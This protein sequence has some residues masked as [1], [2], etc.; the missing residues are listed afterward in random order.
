MNFSLSELLAYQKR[1]PH[2]WRCFVRDLLHI[3]R[4]KIN[5]KSIVVITTESEGLG[6]YLW[7]RNYYKVIKKHFEDKNGCTIILLGMANWKEFVET[8]DL[9]EYL[10]IFRPFESCDSHKFIERLFFYLFTADLYFNFR[11]IYLKNL[12]HAK[13]KILGSGYKAKQCFYEVANNSTFEQWISLPSAFQHTIPIIKFEA[14]WIHKPFVVLVEGGVTQGKLSDSQLVEITTYLLQSNY[15]IFFNGNIHRLTRLIPPSL[16]S[17]IIDGYQYPLYQY[18]YIVEQ[19]M[20]IVTPNSLLYHFAIQLDK[21]CVVLSANEYLTIKQEKKHQV[22]LYNTI[23]EEMINKSIPEQYQEDSS[24]KISQ[25]DSTRI[26]QAIHQLSS[27]EHQ[28]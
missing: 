21:P 5:G 8:V 4:N 13:K 1:H 10:D 18:A 12:V 23:L 14:E 2:Y 9:P 28:L 19:C 26:I 15:L 11:T 24:I 25:F 22:V 16:Q 3:Y 17:R 6:G 27:N 20:Y 7:I